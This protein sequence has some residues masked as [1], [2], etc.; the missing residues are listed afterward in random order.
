MSITE[1][2]RELVR[3][4]Q[5]SRECISTKVIMCK[6]FKDGLN[7]DI[8]LLVRILEIK[9]FVVL[10]ERVCKAEGLRKEKRKVDLEAQEVRKRSSSKSFQ[11]TSKKF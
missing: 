5:Y 10:V 11:M 7:E 3:L 1:Y 4:S 9:E 8:R 6:R 2:E